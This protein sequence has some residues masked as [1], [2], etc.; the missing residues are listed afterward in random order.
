MLMILAMVELVNVVAEVMTI[1]DV[2]H[3]VNGDYGA[4]DG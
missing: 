2:C 3:G 4:D 1:L